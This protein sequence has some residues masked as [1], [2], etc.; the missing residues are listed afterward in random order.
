MTALRVSIC[1]VTV[2]PR[3]LS[4]SDFLITIGCIF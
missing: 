1:C 4:I 3:S 2:G